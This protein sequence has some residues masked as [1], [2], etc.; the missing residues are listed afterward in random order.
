MSAGFINIDGRKIGKG[1]KAFVIAEIAQAHDGSLGMAH[2]YIDLAASSGADA[3]KFQT[4]IAS[5][6]STLNEKFRI[7]LSGQDETRYDYWKRME[8]S[9]E[10]W[11]SLASHARDKGLI[12]LSSA[13]SLEA[14][15]LLKGIGMPAWKVGSGEFRSKEL[16]GAMMVTGAPILLSTGMSKYSEIEDAVSLFRKN[17]APFGI[18]Q[19]TS[20]YPSRLEDVGL[21]VIADFQTTYNVPAG[22]SDHTGS[23]Y[24]SMAAIAR[25]ADMVEVHLTFHKGCYGPDVPASVTKE[26]LEMICTMRDNI[27][28]MDDTPVNKDNFAENNNEMRQ[29]FTKSI[30]PVRHLIAGTVLSDDMLVPRKPG[31]GIPYHEKEK[32]IGLKIIRDV[33]PDRLLDFED[34]EKQN[35]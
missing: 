6:E 13:F 7:P 18:F 5:G 30:A 33:F 29:L 23:P 8:F 32:I 14:V 22:L 12:F 31:T 35:A 3:V 24:P 26:E 19:C 15:E 2:A 10:Q 1:C 16:L 17:N 27:A 20:R 21:N 11:Q 4:H 9:P 34:L 25:G 28:I